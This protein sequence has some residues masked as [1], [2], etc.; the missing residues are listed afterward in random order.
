[1][2]CFFN[3]AI[4]NKYVNKIIKLRRLWGIQKNTEAEEN[5][6]VLG[7]VIKEE[8]KRNNFFLNNLIFLQIFI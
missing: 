7:D 4:S 1:L 6:E 8:I 3:N 5:A 2:I